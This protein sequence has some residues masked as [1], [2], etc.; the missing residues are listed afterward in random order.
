[1]EPRLAVVKRPGTGSSSCWSTSGS[2][3]SN[4]GASV[5]AYYRVKAYRVSTILLFTAGAGRA[6][7]L[8]RQGLSPASGSLASSSP[9]S[10]YSRRHRW[11]VVRSYEPLAFDAITGGRQ[12]RPVLLGGLSGRFA[13]ADQLLRRSSS[14]GCRSSWSRTTSHTLGQQHPLRCRSPPAY[15]MADGN[16]FGWGHRDAACLGLHSAGRRPVL[17][18]PVGLGRRC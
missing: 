9:R 16:E 12:P 6:R 4:T 17:L 11:A 1:M 8:R 15:F 5:E 14:P 18:K 7:P 3:P 2:R 13:P 10:W